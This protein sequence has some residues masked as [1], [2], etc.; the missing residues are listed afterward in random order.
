[1]LIERL[2]VKIVLIPHVTGPDDSKD[3]RGTVKKVYE[4]IEKKNDVKM[5][6]TDYPPWDLKGIIGALDLFIGTRMHS[7]IAAL[8]SCVPTIALAYSHKAYGIMSMLGQDRWVLNVRHFTSSDLVSLTE[9]AW[10]TREI[11]KKDLT[12]R[13]PL[14]QEMAVRNAHFARQMLDN[15]F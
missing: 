14:A 9:M 2:G 13:M 1:M 4:T 11:T 12:G 5:I 8:S 6:L 10:K 7:N 15:S 3:D